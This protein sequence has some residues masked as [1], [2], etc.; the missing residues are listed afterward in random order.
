MRRRLFLAMA[1][2]GLA[3]CDSG[4]TSDDIE[5]ALNGLAASSPVLK[6]VTTL[7]VSDP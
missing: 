5:K 7:V 4:P 3:A 6:G 2:F 1:V